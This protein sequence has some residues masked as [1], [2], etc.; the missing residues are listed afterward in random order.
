MEQAKSVLLIEDEGSIRQ[1]LAKKLTETGLNVL[2]ADDGGTGLELA[3]GEHPHAIILDIIVPEIDG[4]GVMQC[5]RDDAWGKD[6]P[7]VVLTNLSED[8]QQSM[9]ILEHDPV[10]FL[11]KADWS[12]KDVVGK[13]TDCL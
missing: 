6:V 13:I 12:I 10:F 5:L 1:I 11:V 3:F 7:V 2:E 9:Q 4:V 8:D